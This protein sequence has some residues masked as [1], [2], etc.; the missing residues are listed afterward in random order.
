M[1]RL[2]VLAGAGRAVLCL[3][4]D[5]LCRAGGPVSSL[6]K[7]LYSPNH[8]ARTDQAAC[9][10]HEGSP[11]PA[12]TLPLLVAHLMAC[13][14]AFRRPAMRAQ[15]SRE[16][17]RRPS[18][19]APCRELSQPPIRTVTIS[20]QERSSINSKCAYISPCQMRRY[21]GTAEGGGKAPLGS[22]DA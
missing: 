2:E 18:N 20:L 9:P 8:P 5:A 7:C 4:A 13:S 19:R 17:E 14:L 22:L 15:T 16:G 3:H 1:V 11:F 10:L 6:H 21:W 12:P